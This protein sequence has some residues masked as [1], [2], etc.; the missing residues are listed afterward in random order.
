MRERERGLKRRDLH[1]SN[2]DI[3]DCEF[4]LK[5]GVMSYSGGTVKERLRKNKHFVTTITA[6]LA[7]RKGA[8]EDDS[9]CVYC[10]I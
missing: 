7:R 9:K 6:E 4:A 8:I 3:L 1:E 10:R 2:L 5:C